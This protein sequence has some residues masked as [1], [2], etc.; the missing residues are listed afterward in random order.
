MNLFLRILKGIGKVLLVAALVFTLAFPYVLIYKLEKANKTT[1]AKLQELYDGQVENSAFLGQVG[2]LT[3]L[4]AMAV[5]GQGDAIAELQDSVI[6]QQKAA[7][8]VKNE[9]QEVRKETVYKINKVAS[10]IEDNQNKP[11]Y[12]YLK[13]VTVIIFQEEKDNPGSNHGSLGTGVLLK[14]K[15]GHSYILTNKHVCNPEESGT[16]YIIER[17]ENG[18]KVSKVEARPYK[19][20][21]A[22]YDAQVLES[23]TVIEGKQEIRGISHAKPQD[24]VYLVGHHLGRPYIYGEGVFA[25]YETKYLDVIQIPILWGDSG[26]G[27]FDRD[28]RLVAL[29]FAGNAEEQEGIMVWDVAHGLAV[30]SDVLEYLCKGIV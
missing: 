27:V 17:D 1:K 8:E 29:M 16:C 2:L 26:S 18:K 25:G 22:N 12:D 11:S 10:S 23:K 5:Q 24:A 20:I 21:K 30:D 28:G 7:T 3:L 15:D 14:N 9:I 13:S 19:V 6:A 4:L